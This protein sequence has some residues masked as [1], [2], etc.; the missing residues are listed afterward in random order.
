LKG[1]GGRLLHVILGEVDVN[2]VVVVSATLVSADTIIIF[3]LV[4]V[5]IVES[6]K[7]NAKAAAV[8]AVDSRVPCFYPL[9]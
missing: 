3:T 1:N 8:S 2:V 7:G 4:V 9:N 6:S 5:L